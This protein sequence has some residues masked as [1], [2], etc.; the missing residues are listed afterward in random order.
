MTAGS[1]GATREDSGP[2]VPLPR[3][4]RRRLGDLAYEEVRKRIVSGDFRMGSRLNEVR[5]AA[6]LGVSRAPVREALRRLSEEGLVVERP[7]LGAVVKE[8]DAAS[9]VDLYNVRASLE[10]L[11]IRL[12]TRRHMDTKPL[13]EL[14][15]QM[16]VAAQSRDYALVARHELDFHSVI[17]QS[18]SNAVL[19]SIFRALEAQILMGLALDDSGY[20]DLE[21]VAREHE[22]L[23]EMIEAG[24]EDGAA[25]AMPQHVLSTLGS[26]IERLGGSPSDLI[27]R[28]EG[29][30]AGVEAPAPRS[31]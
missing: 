5:L 6:D 19:I 2:S 31:V 20:P 26:L 16:A 11:A 15:R 4:E 28:S 23:V 3:I 24:D 17:I 14:I 7:H 8:I 27:L 1:R 25:K 9:L 21:E 13:R 29:V 30:S 12:A 22:P 18:S 10:S